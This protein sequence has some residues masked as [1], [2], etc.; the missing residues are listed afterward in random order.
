[1]LTVDT[2]EESIANIY[3]YRHAS[4]VGSYFVWFW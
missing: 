3:L 2:F 4:L 1:V